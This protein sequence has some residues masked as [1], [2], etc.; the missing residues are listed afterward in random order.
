MDSIAAWI[1]I[2]AGIAAAAQVFATVTRRIRQVRALHQGRLRQVADLSREVR[3]KARATLDL[4]REEKA[5]AKE[6]QDLSGHIDTGEQVVQ[7]KRAAESFIHVLDERRNPGD[8]PFLVT[9]RHP[10]FAE[11]ARH[12]PRDVVGSWSDGRRYLVWANAPKMAGAKAAMRFNADRGFQVGPPE[13]FDGKA[14]E[15]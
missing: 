15:L 10:N 12:P 11:I 9:I 14:D 5:M 1:G 8:H 3:E 7:R 2:I 4:R 13:P 6:M